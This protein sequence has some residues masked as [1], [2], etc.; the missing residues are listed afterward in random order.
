MN[1]FGIFFPFHY[2]RVLIEENGKILFRILNKS[3]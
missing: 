3:E 2:L 1:C